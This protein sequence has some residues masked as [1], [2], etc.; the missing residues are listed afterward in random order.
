MTESA[1]VEKNEEIFDEFDSFSKIA[2]S[3]GTVKSDSIKIE[4][5]NLD[6][7]VVKADSDKNKK[8]MDLLNNIGDSDG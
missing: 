5:K 4:G 1:V 7:T 2:K 3:I 8:V 6:R